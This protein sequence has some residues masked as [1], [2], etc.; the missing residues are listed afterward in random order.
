M[1][2]TLPHHMLN[3]NDVRS[4]KRIQEQQRETTREDDEEST[5][6]TDRENNEELNVE[7][8]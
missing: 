8:F 7:I 2:V 6:S 4:S 5:R 3:I 1:V